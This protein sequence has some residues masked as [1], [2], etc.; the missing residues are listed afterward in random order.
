MNNYKQK[1]EYV[2]SPGV[3]YVNK[4]DGGLTLFNL[5][6]RADQLPAPDKDGNIKLT[7]FKNDYKKSA[8]QPD[9]NFRVP[10]EQTAPQR[11]ANGNATARPKQKDAPEQDSDA[12][13]SDWF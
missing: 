1:S 11:N 9:I 12:G 10:R 8:K 5:I 2:P 4:K 3:I 13:G 7:G 6:L